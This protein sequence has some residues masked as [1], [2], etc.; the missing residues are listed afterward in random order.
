MVP[1]VILYLVPQDYLDRA[2][3]VFTLKEKEGKSAETRV[4]ILTDAWTILKEQPFGV[5]VAAFQ[6]VRKERF[7]R[8]Q[9]T[10]NLYLQVATNLGVHGL[11]VF[12]VFIALMWRAL[13]RSGRLLGA[14]AARLTERVADA[15]GGSPELVKHLSDVEFMR[16]TA[17]AVELFLVIR[18][19]LGMFG[20]DL[21]EIYWWFSLGLTVALH[22]LSQLADRRTDELLAVPPRP[23]PL[24]RPALARASRLA[25]T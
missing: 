19:A 23:M 13:R 4:E 20:M 6:V 10:H 3:T 17:V 16:A 25:T 15:G 5:G 11:V 8:V 1:A 21:Y 12:L 24:P 18:L 7:G 22:H 14:Q 2:Y 9:D